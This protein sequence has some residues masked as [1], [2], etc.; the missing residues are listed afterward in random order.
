MNFKQLYAL[1]K[2]TRE[3]LNSSMHQNEQIL[4]LIG[5]IAT[6]TKL[7]EELQ[8]KLDDLSREVKMMPAPLPFPS[9]YRP[10]PPKNPWEVPG[11]PP[12]WNDH[13]AGCRCPRC[14]PRDYGPIF[15]CKSS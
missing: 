4:Q 10:M 15:T 1:I 12:K 3:Q 5:Q 6:L 13:G 9:P 11:P 8:S 2:Q 14:E 7:V